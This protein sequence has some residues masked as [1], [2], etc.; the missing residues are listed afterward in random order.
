MKAAQSTRKQ[1]ALAQ[2]QALEDELES[3]K[4]AA[5]IELESKKQAVALEQRG[6]SLTRT[7]SEQSCAVSAVS[8][9][10][11][12]LF[13]TTVASGRGQR[14]M[15]LRVQPSAGLHAAGPEHCC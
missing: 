9:R 15:M 12:L 6:A 1:T 4:Q 14:A 11:A 7:S 8:A 13:T 2:A 5:T 10:A 3:K